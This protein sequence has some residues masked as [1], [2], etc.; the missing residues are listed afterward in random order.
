[1]PANLLKY[2]V[3]GFLCWSEFHP[4]KWQPIDQ[5]TCT[6]T[7]TCRGCGRVFRRVAHE[8]DGRWAY[9]NLGSCGQHQ[10]CSYCGQWHGH[11][12]EHDCEGSY[13]MA[14]ELEVR[15]SVRGA[16]STCAV[17]PFRTL[18][19]SSSMLESLPRA[20]ARAGSVA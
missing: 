2:A 3:Y 4:V 19:S 12:I 6:Q 16:G 7:G 18:E 11:R 15:S 10:F 9:M 5:E 17:I 1:M 13:W 14:K 8:P 20:E